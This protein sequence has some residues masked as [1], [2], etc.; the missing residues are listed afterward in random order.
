MA[1]DDREEALNILRGI[2]ERTGSSEDGLIARSRLGEIA[3]AEGRFDE[4]STIVAEIL[5][6]DGSNIA[7]LEMRG[8]MHLDND[9][10]D[11][12]IQD[13]RIVL[14]EKPDSSRA[15]LLLSR[16]YE[17]TGSIELADD[18]LADALRY[19][20]NNVEIAITYANFLIKQSAA[21]RAEDVLIGVLNVNPN[22]IELLRTLARVRLMRQNWI[23][24]QQI[25]EAIRRL[26]SDDA[27][28]TEIEGIALSGQ[29]NY[30][31]SI[32]LFRNAYRQGQGSASGTLTSLVASY[33]RAN[34][35]QEAKD[36]LGGL[37]EENENNY[38]AHLLLGQVHMGLSETEQGIAMFEKAIQLEPTNVSAYMNLISHY[39]RADDVPKSLELAEQ[40]LSTAS[41]PFALLLIK[42]SI[43]ERQKD[44]EMS[45]SI[46]E[47]MME[48]DLTND[49]VVNNLA[50]LLSEHRTDQASMARAQELA[51]RF[52][53]SAVPH[54]KDTLGWI[55]YKTGDIQAAT[56]ILQDAVE[57]MPNVVIFRYHLG[58]SYMEEGRNAAAIREFEEVVKLSDNQPFEQLE[59]VK[60]LLAEL[61]A[62]G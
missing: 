13:L 30:D 60:G 54:F 31:Q 62:A 42:A 61:N 25:A 8:S 18:A 41:N 44:F 15:S 52:R 28:A 5:E 48:Q 9:R 38:Q 12:A 36:F 33:M 3:M 24:A 6:I 34:R 7:A 51:S 19:S 59:E 50:S 37:I 47:D 40:G 29:Q 46:Y 27:A 45:I 57:Q 32:T 35:P 4:A 10:Y 55:Y 22:N 2:V 23:G 53:Q 11:N 49:V 26:D 14:N 56:S 17:L 1:N 21:P 39:V 43:Y 16:A 58:M 20:D